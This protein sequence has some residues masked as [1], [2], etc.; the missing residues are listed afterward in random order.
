[1]ADGQIGWLVIAQSY[2]L[3]KKPD[4]VVILHHLVE[5]K[6]AVDHQ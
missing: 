5:E 1:M 4:I 3:K 6:T 2:V